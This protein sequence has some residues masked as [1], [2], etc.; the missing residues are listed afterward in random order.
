[1]PLG[2]QEFMTTLGLGILND[3]IR[4][5]SPNRIGREYKTTQERWREFYFW[6]EGSDVLTKERVLESI[7]VADTG[8]GD[9]VIFH[10]S[11][12]K[13]LYLLPANDHKIL[14]IGSSLS[15]AIDWMLHWEKLFGEDEEDEDP[16]PAGVYF[17]PF[18]MQD[19]Q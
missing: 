7:I 2:Y 10:P 12:P 16:R 1:M 11:I 8:N 4:V 14:E 13:K 17:E 15:E 3:T 18:H 9:E 6:G 19:N 5:Y